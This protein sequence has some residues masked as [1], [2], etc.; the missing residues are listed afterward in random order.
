MGEAAIIGGRACWLFRMGQRWTANESIDG[1]GRD[2]LGAS[3][4][5]ATLCSKRPE[6]KPDPGAPAPR[7]KRRA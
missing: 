6:A 3:C 7:P 5:P 1:R 2:E 4:V